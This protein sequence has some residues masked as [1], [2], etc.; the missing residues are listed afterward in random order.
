MMIAL[1]R[2]CNNTASTADA[3]KSE[4]LFGMK[5]EIPSDNFTF[6]GNNFSHLDI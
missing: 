6:K 3:M 5:C 1:N 4:V 2:S